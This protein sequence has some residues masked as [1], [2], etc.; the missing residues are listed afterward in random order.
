MNLF[1]AI[2]NMLQRKQKM[3]VFYAKILSVALLLSLLFQVSNAL[4]KHFYL[5]LLFLN[6]FQEHRDQSGIVYRFC[7]LAVL[8]HQ[9]VL[10]P[11]SL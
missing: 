4:F 8:T 2:R 5:G 6:G 9:S 10:L 7:T 3:R 1:P 11:V